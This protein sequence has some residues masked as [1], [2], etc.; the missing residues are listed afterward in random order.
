MKSILIFLL[1]TSY[2]Y[3]SSL[4][5]DIGQTTTNFN[6]FSIP[7]SITDRITTP[8]EET[9]NS[10]RL[11]GFFDL[12]SKNQLYVMLAP[13]EVNYEFVSPK[14]FTFNNTNFTQAVDTKVKYKFNSYRLGYLWTWSFSRYRYWLGAVGKIRDAEIEVKQ[15]SASD[16]YDNIGFVPLLSFG[17]EWALTANLQI[18][19][20][21]DALGA[22]QGSAYDSQIE[23][24]YKMS[25][26]SISL[27]K[28]VLGGGADNDRVYNFAQFDTFYF[29]LSTYF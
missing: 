24:K 18:F 12:S 14:N 15:A 4:N 23:L 5:L 7:K 11:T 19:H 29:K 10:Y 8:T 1:L 28:R 17:F 13:L 21:T 2:C 25:N 20:H 9:L 16:S 3:G 27:G 22:S 26:S 6:R